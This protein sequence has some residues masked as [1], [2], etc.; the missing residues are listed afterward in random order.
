VW[1]EPAAVGIK[2]INRSVANVSRG[3]PRAQGLTIVF[4]RETAY[5]VA[6]MESAYLS[7]MRTSA[8]T[9]LSVQLLGPASPHKVAV[10]GCGYLGETHIRMLAPAMPD[11]RFALYDTSIARRDALV[12]AVV[13]AG[14]S[15]GRRTPPRRRCARLT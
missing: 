6:V 5:P 4:D 9:A 12:G 3:I 14:S 8:Y 1:G 10:T 11:A 15:S 7:A 13:R 2:L